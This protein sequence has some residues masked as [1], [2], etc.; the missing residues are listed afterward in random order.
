[1]MLRRFRLSSSAAFALFTSFIATGCATST[2]SVGFSKS[3]LQRIPTPSLRRIVAAHAADEVVAIRMDG[4]DQPVEVKEFNNRDSATIF[5]PD[6]KE[7]E[8]RFSDITALVIFKK[9]K[10]PEP[11]QRPAGASASAVA[12]ATVEALAYAPIVPLAIG[13]WPLL[14]AMGLD[15]SKNSADN[16]KAR[17]I[18]Q[19]MSRQDLLASIG[20]PKEKYSCILKLRLKDKPDVP[21]EI[22]VYDESKVLRGGR[23]LFLDVGTGTVSHN[24]FHTTFF[25]DSDSFDCSPSVA[26]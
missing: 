8:I 2:H 10:P 7:A 12:S 25:R 19:G 16:A 15:E 13:T 4:R 23:A 1:M 6:G 26:P 21:Q 18:Y 11:T 5:G 20:E 24:S 22:W 14:R 17:L 9:P 3:E